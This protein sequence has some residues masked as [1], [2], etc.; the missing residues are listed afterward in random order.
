MGGFGHHLV[1]Q[2]VLTSEQLDEA[3]RFQ[4]VYGGRTGTVVVD[5]GYLVVEELAEHLSDHTCVPLPPPEWLETPDSNALKQVPPPLIRRCQALPLSL[6]GGDLHVAMLDPTDPEKLDFLAMA[7]SRPVVPYVLPERRLLYWLEVHC[8]I[9][10]PPRFLGMLTQPRQIGLTPEELEAGTPMLDTRERIAHV[11][12]KSK[13]RAE[14]AVAVAVAVG[15]ATAV[16]DELSAAPT[17]PPEPPLPA[18]PASGNDREDDEILLLDELVA[19]APAETS[20]W[21]ISNPAPQAAQVGNETASTE[22]LS[23]RLARLESELYQSR[24]R[25]EVI[26][27]ALEIASS[28]C[29]S[30]ALF[31][32]RGETVSL[33]RAHGEAPPASADELTIPIHM[34]SLFTQ[35]AQTGLPFRGHPPSGGVD[36]RVLEGLRREAVQEILVHPVVIRDRV[37]NLL[38][39]DNGGEVFG[40]TSI[41][42][43]TALGQTLSRA[44]ER[45]IAD[46]KQKRKT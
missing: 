41:G 24:N 8:G 34:P 5:L 31:V 26:A 39:A 16:S 11:S 21:E 4:Q 13:A 2:G 27:L 1:E 40:E 20:A 9:D 19:E 42:A 46:Q 38:Y 17:A 35:P 6:E 23:H 45:L 3:L 7:S 44:Y 10:R 43:L 33:F 25:D 30:T 22:S 29:E 37:V 15:D 28:F 12:A 18:I 32:V 14:P 36:G